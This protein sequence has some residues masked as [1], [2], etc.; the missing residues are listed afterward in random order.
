MS[1][2]SA[3]K[4]V[5]PAASVILAVLCAGCS[6][7]QADGVRYATL[8]DVVEYAGQA[9]NG[10]DFRLFAPDADEAADLRSSSP[11]NTGELKEGEC[12]LLAYVPRNGEAYTSGTVD[13]TGVG[14][15]SNDRLLKGKPETLDGWDADPVWVSS[16]WRAGGKIVM[17]IKL[18]YDPEPRVFRL[19]VDETTM[20]DEYPEAYLVNMRHGDAENFLRQYYV[21]FDVHAMWTYST[22]KGLR[23]HINNSNDTSLKEFVIE[24]PASYTSG[25]G[26]DIPDGSDAAGDKQTEKN[27]Q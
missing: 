5:V 9:D 16:L 2:K 26:E 10:T 13:V 25:G 11:V 24:K 19:V 23:I 21:A 4:T 22:C 18:V 12:L 17:R 20:A 6:D 27:N 14:V 1:Y 8:Y 3:H 7:G 15:V